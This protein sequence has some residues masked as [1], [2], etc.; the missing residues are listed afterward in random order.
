MFVL[1]SI[2]KHHRGLSFIEESFDG[3]HLLFGSFIEETF[4]ASVSQGLLMPQPFR[5]YSSA[6]DQMFPGCGECCGKLLEFA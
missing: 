5:C 2:L 6:T 3:F 4:D 1:Q